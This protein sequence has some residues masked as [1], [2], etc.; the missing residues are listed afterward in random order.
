MSNE[1]SNSTLKLIKKIELTVIM[2]LITGLHIGASKDNVEI[3]GIDNPVVRVKLKNNQPYIP[4][5]SLKGK[6]RS[7][8]EIA[9]GKDL[10]EDI[11]INRLFGY[12]GKNAE[13][14]RLIVRDAYLTSDSAEELESVE[15]DMPYTEAKFENSINRIKGTATDPRQIERVPAGAKFQVNFVLN[16]YKKIGETTEED[17]KDKLI[18]LLKTSIELLKKDYLGGSGTRGYGQ[19]DFE[20]ELK[21]TIYEVKEE[22]GELKFLKN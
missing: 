7:L 18:K 9:K 20:S 17:D 3:G 19:V 1:N 15:L 22:N 8:L 12:I 11:E 13:P 21:E 2:K 4:G 16:I 5:S 10:G 6:L 14:S